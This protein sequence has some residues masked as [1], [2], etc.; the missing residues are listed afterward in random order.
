M[1]LSLANGATYRKMG[2]RT[3]LLPCLTWESFFM[4]TPHF[5]TYYKYDQLTDI[6]QGYSRSHPHL[7][8]LQEIGRSHEERAI[9]LATVTNFATGTDRDKPAFWVDANLHAAELAGC[10]ASLHLLETLLSQYGQVDDVTR[11][12][13]ERVFYICPRA[14]PDG[15]E[16][17]LA[18]VPRL[19]RS[20]TRPY[21]YD[22]QPL[23]AMLSEDVDGDGRILTMR[24]PDP[25]GNWKISDQEPRLMVPREPTEMGGSYYRLLPEGRIEDY[26]GVTI[27]PL[28]R[29]ENLDLNRNFPAQWRA[30]HE[31]PGA[32]PYPA[33]EPEVRALVD[34]VADHPNICGGVSY[35][36]YS[37]VLL[38]PYSY[39]A[40][41]KMPAEDLW[42][43]QKIGAKGTALT[44]YPAVSAFHDFQYHPQQVIT[45][46]MDD[47]LY[48]ER[49]LFAWTVEIWSPQRQAGIEQGKFIEWYR[50][51]PFEDDLK[52][53]A[54]SDTALEGKGYIDWY[55]FEHPQLGAIEL[56]GWDPLYCF[57]NPPP[58]LLE[59]E[60]A[61]LSEWLVWHNLIGPRLTLHSCEA[62]P[63]GD[64]SYRIRLTVQ[65]SGWLPSYCTKQALNKHYARG[66][67]CEITLPDGARLTQGQRRQELGQ[68]EGRAYKP[69]SPITWIGQTE[70]A[71]DD[72]LK[73]EWVVHATAG[74]V[75][76][77]SARHERAGRVS[78]TLTL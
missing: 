65:N 76:E 42:T 43:F 63:L 15:A 35:H 64:D 10:M 55:P 18:D 9:W 6:L 28:S 2:A 36:T 1:E 20:S 70:D 22:E 39:Q 5:D 21:P 17:A 47:W 3:I 24:I 12:L 30:E 33:S 68:L 7:F 62:L 49:G 32:G 48:D 69:N 26:D 51:H 13:D 46:S 67:V 29:K 56:G 50:D 44:G 74:S 11:C 58:K 66:T 16:W 53:L 37:G 60:I 52:L 40:D 41:E 77:V 73:V 31:Q 19:V 34:F 45:G 8:Q 57:W 71:T 23:G 27:G 38:R 54:W 59:K 61:P 4:S 14:N 78:Q 75:I 25:N 72:R